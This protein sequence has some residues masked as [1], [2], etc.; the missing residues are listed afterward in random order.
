MKK[1]NLINNL[2]LFIPILILMVIS[3]LNMLKI[4]N[5]LSIYKNYAF[6][7]TLW[8][9]LGFIIMAIII[10]VK[11]KFIF[12]Y[13]KYFYYINVLLL[14]LV[15][16][17][18]K[19]VNG[20]KAWFDFG[21]FSFQPS[22]LMKF[23][24]ALHLANSL[25]KPK[26]NNFKSELKLIFKAIFYTLIPSLFVFL[27]PDTGTIII[28]LFIMIGM[29]MVNGISKKWYIVL[30]LLVL[31]F[32]GG[33]LYLYYFNK[34]LLIEMM[35]TSFFYRVDRILTFVNNNSFQLD[36]ALISIGVSS[37]FNTNSFVYIPEAPTDFIIALT[38]NNLGVI[39]FIIILICLFILDVYFIYRMFK[40]KNL[41][42]KMFY[43]GFIMMFVFAQIQNIG[44]NLGILPIIGLPLPFVSY[45]GTN[46][47]V[48]FMFLGVLASL[49]K[50]NC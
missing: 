12:K 39:S 38:I 37:L 33:F 15:L 35:G 18:G 13:S 22:E 32:L 28:Y 34:D 49:N 29:I 43:A 10:F 27:E 8:F 40:I 30:G 31:M 23:T 7:Q 16:F 2:V 41:K 3:I 45:G 20:S 48:Y 9:C 46:I 19:T 44:M 1:K 21:F 24:L 50:K 14:V 6:K 17:V 26:K 36:R 4:G 25:E 11:P 5:V 47:M 42:F